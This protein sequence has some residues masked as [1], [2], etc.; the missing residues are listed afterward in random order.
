GFNHNVQD[1]QAADTRA[2]ELL[3][4][5]PYKDK[6]DNAGLFLKAL[7]SR[8]AALQGLVRPHLGNPLAAENRVIRMPE[9]MN[10]AP[11]LEMSKR[12]QVPALPLGGRVKIDPWNDRAELIKSPAVSLVS[13]REKM[14][15]EVTPVFPHLSRQA[16]GSS[17]TAQNSPSPQTQPS[18]AGSLKHE[19]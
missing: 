2:L 9:L 19:N 16:S 12:D 1:E 17:D 5:S 3:Q 6:L 7:E 13:A 10:K 15:F 14:L 8:V 4:N 18:A 11:Q